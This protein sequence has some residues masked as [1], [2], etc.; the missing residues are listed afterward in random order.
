MPEMPGHSSE[1]CDSVI[2]PHIHID[3]PFL[4][5]HDGQTHSD[6]IIPVLTGQLP[7]PHFPKTVADIDVS[8]FEKFGEVICYPNSTGENAAERI[9]DAQ[10]VISNSDSIIANSN[11]CCATAGVQ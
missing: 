9:G 2:D 3:K 4:K 5:H 11:V 6:R 7:G 10:I 1:R 8:C